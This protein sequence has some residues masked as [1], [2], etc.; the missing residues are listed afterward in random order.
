MEAW[1]SERLKV[2]LP[3]LAECSV[4]DETQIAQVCGETIEALHNRGLGSM[5]SYKRP[6]REMRNA[7]RD[8][9]AQ[10]AGNVC[11]LHG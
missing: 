8:L 9:A 3:A 6:M 11:G 4:A 7:L 10:S 5:L 2:L 1:V